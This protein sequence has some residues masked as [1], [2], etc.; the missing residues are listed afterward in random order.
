MTQDAKRITQNDN[1]SGITLFDLLS[2]LAII[3]ILMGFLIPTIS[4]VKNRARATI[5]AAQIRQLALAVAAYSN[6]FEGNFPT[7]LYGATIQK[8]YSNPK[9]IVICPDDLRSFNSESFPRGSY[10]LNQRILNYKLTSLPETS[11]V[12][13]K[14]I[15]ILGD[16]VG[17][18][19]E[20]GTF[21]I[22]HKG[23]GNLAFL[24]GH[25]DSVSS[26]GLQEHL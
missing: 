13:N 19:L 24:D 4:N 6:D 11:D 8:Y 18:T 1:I 22:R 16:A 15:A 20:V 3:C 7:T 9:E 10:G 17:E 2:V 14:P 23:E 5:C 26:L 12:S 25:V 21:K